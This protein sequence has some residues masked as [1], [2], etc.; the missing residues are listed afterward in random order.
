MTGFPK[1]KRRLAAAASRPAAHLRGFARDTSGS[2][3]IETVLILPVLMWAMLATFT[4]VDAYRMQT[5]NLRATYTLSDLLSRQSNPVDA[6]FMGGMAQY[7]EFLTNF[8]HDTI[9]RVTVVR[10]D[11]ANDSHIL[12]WSHSSDP[13]VP[14]IGQGDLPLMSKALPVLADADTAIIVE[15]W[16][17]YAPPFDIGLPGSSFSNRIV[18]SPRF[19]PQ[20]LWSNVAIS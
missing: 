4:Y 1:L 16:M 9:L 18:T 2:S 7:H 3:V 14:A 8:A 11:L 20:L 15:T 5:M 12:V 10:Y 6:A 17:E 19:V 13:S